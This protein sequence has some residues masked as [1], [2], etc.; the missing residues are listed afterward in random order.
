MLLALP[1]VVPEHTR[2]AWR[3]LSARLAAEFPDYPV[4]TEEGWVA[5]PL[6]HYSRADIRVL[7]N[8]S[9]EPCCS[10]RVILICRPIRCTALAGLL[11]QYDQ[12]K[13]ETITWSDSP[14]PASSLELHVFRQRT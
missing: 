3:D 5:L 1:S 6:K 11:M 13:K 4:L 14:G 12:V 8:D 10:P 2:P 9:S 7:A